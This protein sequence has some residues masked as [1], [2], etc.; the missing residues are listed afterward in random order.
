MH[1]EEFAV[2][3]ALLELYNLT[4]KYHDEVSKDTCTIPTAPHSFSDCHKKIKKNIEVMA[5]FV[6]WALIIYIA[7]ANACMPKLVLC[8]VVHVDCCGIS[9]IA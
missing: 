4:V 5:L 2:K 7:T 6:N 9:T 8:S 1:N 3:A